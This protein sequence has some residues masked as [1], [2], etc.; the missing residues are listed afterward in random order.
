M[1]YQIYWDNEHPRPYIF[2]AFTEAVDWG[3]FDQAVTE[4]YNEIKTQAEPFYLI[5][6]ADNIRALP[7]GNPIPHFRRILALVDD[8]AQIRLAI[9]VD[10]GKLVFFSRI[11]QLIIKVY[12]P[13]WHERTI[14]VR[15]LADA[16]KLIAKHLESSE[17]NLPD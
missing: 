15:T 11:V 9:T 5:F 4:L 8:F 12:S 1:A 14:Y 6:L 17:Q 10:G 2:L 13:H 3:E 7:K 16:E